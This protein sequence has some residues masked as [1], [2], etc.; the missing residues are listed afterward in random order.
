MASWLRAFVIV[1]CATLA[2]TL[3]PAPPANA[4]DKVIGVP[5]GDAEMAAAIAKARES[6]PDFWEAWAAPPQGTEGFSLKV[7][8]TDANGS[9]HFWTNTI[10]RKDGHIFANIGN[11][12]DTVQSVVAGQRIEI[13]EADISDWMY[14]H[15]GK[16]VGNETL[17]VLLKYMSKE[18]ADYWRSLLETP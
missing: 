14:W 6:L 10:E 5:S 12:P 4:E 11:E 8:I 9:E 2:A 18:D 16:I 17:R 3:M 15:N 1:V 13:A 7:R